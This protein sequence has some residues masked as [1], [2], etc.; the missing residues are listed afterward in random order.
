MHDEV[1]PCNGY[2]EHDSLGSYSVCRAR[3]P[4][5]S[6]S[7][8][9]GLHTGRFPQ[10]LRTMCSDPFLQATVGRRFL[11]ANRADASCY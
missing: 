5:G 3:R 9:H 10:L 4:A 8:L 7:R 11:T 6:R 1:T 2:L